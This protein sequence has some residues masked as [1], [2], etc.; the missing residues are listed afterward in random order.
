MSVCFF[1][2]V[3]RLLIQ[4][5]HRFAKANHF[6]F[7]YN[8]ENAIGKSGMYATSIMLNL[9]TIE[10][11]SFLRLIFLQFVSKTHRHIPDEFGAVF[12]KFGYMSVYRL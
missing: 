11:P 12:S 7:R 4:L 1:S 2:S 8:E 6:R 3:Y 9:D 5:F 10:I